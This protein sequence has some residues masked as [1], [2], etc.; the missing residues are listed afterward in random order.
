[1]TLEESYEIYKKT[2]IRIFTVCTMITGLIT[3]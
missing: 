2:I 3:I 1:M